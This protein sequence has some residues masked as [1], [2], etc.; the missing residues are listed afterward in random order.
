MSEGGINA[1]G[2]FALGAVITAIGAAQTGT[3][4]P[5]ASLVVLAPCQ[6]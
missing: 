1:A 4:D 3:I 6:L 2:F 5:A